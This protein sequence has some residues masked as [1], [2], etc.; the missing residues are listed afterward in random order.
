MI[1]KILQGI[2]RLQEVAFSISDN[3]PNKPNILLKKYQYSQIST[4]WT[5]K[6]RESKPKNDNKI[7]IV[8]SCE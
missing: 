1:F 4:M 7:E 8:G 2:P 6:Q 3:S 5:L